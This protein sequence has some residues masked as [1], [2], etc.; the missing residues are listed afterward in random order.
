MKKSVFKI[1]SKYEK[2]YSKEKKNMHSVNFVDVSYWL[3]N[4][5]YSII[6]SIL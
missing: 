5:V 4:I 3:Y 1:S 6:Q 2:V